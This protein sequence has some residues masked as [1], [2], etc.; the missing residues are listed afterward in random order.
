MSSPTIADLISSL[1]DNNSL[2]YKAASGAFFHETCRAHCETPDK[3]GDDTVRYVFADNSCLISYGG[4]W[5]LG[6]PNCWCGQDLGH[7]E[8][9]GLFFYELYDS[10]EYPLTYGTVRGEEPELRHRFTH[11]LKPGQRF[12]L[13]RTA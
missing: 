11:D 2:R 13:T 7:L 6:Y 8:P 4:E 5:A 1:F 9:C 3:N 10:E 12:E